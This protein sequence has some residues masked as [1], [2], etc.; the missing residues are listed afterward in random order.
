MPPQPALNLIPTVQQA[1][2]NLLTTYEPEFL[3]FGYNLFL[4]FATILIAWQGICLMFSH[5]GLSEQLF[6][7]A[8]LLL[9]VSFG[10]ALITFYETP[11]PGIGVSFSNLITDQA[12]YFQSVLE[13]RAFDNIY[14]HFDDLSD[15]FLQPDAWS[16]LA[17]L[18]YWTVLL[19]IAF[20]KAVSLAVIAFGLIASAVCGL[21]GPIFVPFFIVPKL[22]WLFWGWLR[23]FIQYSFIPVVA[24]AFLMIFERFVYRYVTT[25]PPTITPAEYGIY[26]LQ[27]FAVVATFCIGILLVPSL[28][29]SIFSGSSGESVLSNRI[30][31]SRVFGRR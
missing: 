23:S 19:L 9:F 8:K 13:A 2:T 6:D 24:V 17:N 21:L 26:A 22:D 20:A 28:T 11:L 14:H 27:A 10:Y 16:I 7:F 4:A 31:V 18:I 25:L 5:D 30:S 15:H 29:Q 1:I 3:R 12:F